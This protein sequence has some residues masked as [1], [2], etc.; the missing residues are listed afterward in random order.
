MNGERGISLIETLIVSTLTLFVMGAAF[1]IIVHFGNAQK[2]EGARTRLSEEARYMFNAFSEELKDAGAMLTIAN[3]NSF[4]N[5][6]PYFNGIFP[7]DKTDGPDG[8]ILASGDPD[9]VTT[10][11]VSYT[12]PGTTINVNSTKKSDGT[13]AWAAGDKGIIIAANG[14]YVFQVTAA[15]ATSL[16]VR[17]TPVYYSG[18]L[19]NCGTYQYTDTLRTP[20]T[21][22][23]S[24]LSYTGGASAPFTPVIRLTNFG[25]Y[26]F[27]REFDTQLNRN[28]NRLFRITDTGGVGGTAL[29]TNNQSIVSDNIFDLQLSYT[30]Y[31]AFP[32]ATPNY[33]F[34]ASSTD[35]TLPAPYSTDTAYSLIQKKYLKEVDATIVVLTDNYQGKGAVPRTI[36][37][38]KNRPGYTLPAGKYNYKLYDYNIQNKNYNIV[39]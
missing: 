26:L 12:P 22:K 27:D 18:L 6:Y 29:L 31:T 9:G 17:D 4:L 19:S 1:N 24:Q 34:F 33:S 11:T 30:F 36:P 23:G 7:L 21:V 39:F 5:D 37:A 32:N 15:D 16:T 38:I 25:I 10:L 2:N 35:P 13:F 28:I 14:Y 8:V 3:T 20:A